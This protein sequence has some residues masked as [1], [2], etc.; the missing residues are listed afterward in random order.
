MFVPESHVSPGPL[1]RH[2]TE[3]VRQHVTWQAT[4]AS[5]GHAGAHAACVGHGTLGHLGDRELAS[6]SRL[7]PLAASDTA[8][9]ATVSKAQA[10]WCRN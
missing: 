9:D 5:I 4:D 8:V 10:A 2:G 7:L 1:V 3:D 6:R